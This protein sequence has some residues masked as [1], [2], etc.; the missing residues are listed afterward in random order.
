MGISALSA[1]AGVGKSKIAEDLTIARA[2]GGAWLGLPVAPGPAL[3]WSA[4]QGKDET[5]A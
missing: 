2:T 3:F 5:F 1:K 4:E